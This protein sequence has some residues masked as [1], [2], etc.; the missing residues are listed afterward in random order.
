VQVSAEILKVLR[1]RA[2]EALGGSSFGV[3]VTVPGYFD[4]S[5]RQATKDAARLAGLNVL[6]LLNEPTAAAIAY[7]LDHGSR[8]R[9]P[10]STWAAAPSTSRSSSSPA[11]SSRCSRPTATRRSAATTSTRRSRC[12]GARNCSSPT[13]A[14]RR[15]L[16]T[17]ARDV[18]ERLSS[19]D[20]ADAHVV[21]SYGQKLH[22]HL[23]R[24]EFESMTASLVQKTLAPVRQALRDA[25]LKTGDIDGVVLVG[26]ATR[27]PHL[28]RAV[29]GFF[30]KPP[31]KDLDP[32]RS[33]P[34]ARPSRRTFSRATG[35]RA[36]TGCCST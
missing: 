24:T 26:G 6:R 29:E 12:T 7:G 21:L 5:Q 13:R 23:T 11:E 4:D 16:L 17:V 36:T 33:W 34:S 31:L 22:V 1:K 2:E 27:M 35:R 25:K 10:S 15:R 8:A 14:T 19:A 18:K 9:S 32:T 28:Q 3:V 30:G 20:S